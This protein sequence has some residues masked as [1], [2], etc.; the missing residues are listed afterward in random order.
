MSG[1]TGKA[2]RTFAECFRQRRAT[3]GRPYMTESMKTWRGTARN[4]SGG[5]G[6]RQEPAGERKKKRFT[7]SDGDS[8]RSAIMVSSF[9][10]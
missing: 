2:T 3:G 4:L 6:A 10:L 9:G 5:A 1:K 8:L 7:D